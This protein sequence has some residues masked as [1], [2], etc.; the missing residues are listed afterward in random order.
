M[1][2]PARQWLVAEVGE[3]L[4]SGRRVEARAEQAHGESAVWFPKIKFEKITRGVRRWRIAPLFPGYVMMRVRPVEARRIRGVRDLVKIGE[5]IAWIRN[6]EIRQK[7]SQEDERGFFVITRE[8][9][10]KFTRGQRVS[11]LEG[12]M[13]VAHGIYQGL[14][15][16]GF[17]RVAFQLLEREIVKAYSEDALEAA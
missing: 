9:V 5:Q 16:R 15:E 3:G 6:S 4:D 7:R 2:R 1:G 13:S 14:D 11:L 17:C 10:E 8:I 12:V